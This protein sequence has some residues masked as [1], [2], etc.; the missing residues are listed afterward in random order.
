MKK[1]IPFAKQ[2]IRFD[3][4][5]ST[6]T[7]PGRN[8]TRTF[9]KTE[10][11]FGLQNLP[12]IR[13]ENRFASNQTHSTI[14]F[15]RSNSEEKTIHLNTC[16]YVPGDTLKTD[17][18]TKVTSA[19]KHQHMHAGSCHPTYQVCGPFC[20]SPTSSSNVRQDPLEAILVIFGR[21]PLIFFCLKALGKN[22]KWHHFCAHAQWWSLWRRKN[23]EKGDLALSNLTFFYYLR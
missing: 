10:P 17:L 21:R 18:N 14:R 9:P 20:S 4:F 5:G 12:N 15:T 13:D 2:K 7:R 22:E 16:V 11:K 1:K 23:V 8:L 3:F 6:P 19:E